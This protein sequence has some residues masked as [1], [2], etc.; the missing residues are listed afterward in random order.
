[1]GGEDALIGLRS[2]V[3]F[4]CSTERHVKLGGRLRVPVAE[5]QPVC[6]LWIF[7]PRVFPE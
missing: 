4:G 5:D 3:A 1:M 7:H 2:P 6:N